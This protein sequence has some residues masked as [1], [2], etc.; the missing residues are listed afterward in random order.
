MTRL[1][2]VAV[3]VTA[4]YLAVGCTSPQGA[5]EFRVG[6]SAPMQAEVTYSDRVAIKS[7]LD[8]TASKF[9]LVEQASDLWSDAA[10]SYI[11]DPERHPAAK[12]NLDAEF[13]HNRMVVHLTGDISV[14]FDELKLYLHKRLAE[15]FRGRVVLLER[16]PQGPVERQ[17]LPGRLE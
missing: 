4:V 9:H 8:I 7:L 1:T 6:P 5:V 16:Q 11:Y 17:S 3:V 10:A 2:L 15:M 14:T 12:I 13:V